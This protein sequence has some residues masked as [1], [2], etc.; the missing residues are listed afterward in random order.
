MSST[1]IDY[2]DVQGTLLRGYR[3]DMARHFVLNI[4]SAAKAGAFIAGLADGTGGLPRITTAARWKVKPECF[5]N[6]AFT[7]AGLTALGVPAQQLATFDQGFQRGATNPVTAQTVG[8]V[9]DSAPANWI[10][11]LANGAAVHLILSLWVD[12]DS[13][14]LEKVTA[15][16][17]AAFEKPRRFEF[18]DGSCCRDEQGFLTEAARK[19]VLEEF[20]HDFPEA[21][22]G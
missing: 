15:T 16:L 17:R 13:A 1:A 5:V 3:V 20:D 11:G 4:T 21:Q 14:V 19:A 9:G 12:D 6:V 22:H 7:A 18:C 8:D 10:A 2:A